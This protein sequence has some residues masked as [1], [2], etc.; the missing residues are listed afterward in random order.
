MASNQTALPNVSETEE[1]LLSGTNENVYED[2]NIGA[3]LTK[4]ISTVLPGVQCCCRPLLTTT[5][6]GIRMAVRPV[7]CSEKRSTPISAIWRV[8]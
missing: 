4:K 1:T 3:E 5:Y 2:Q 7:T 8:R 6:A